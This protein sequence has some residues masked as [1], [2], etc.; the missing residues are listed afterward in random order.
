MHFF[1]QTRFPLRVTFGFLG[2]DVIDPERADV[3]IQSPPVTYLTHI[4]HHTSYN[5]DGV[6]TCGRC[7]LTHADIHVIPGELLRSDPC[8][9]IG[10]NLC[11]LFGT[12]SCDL[13]STPNHPMSRL[14]GGHLFLTHDTLGRLPNSF[15]EPHLEAFF[16]DE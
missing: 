15:W 5:V 1:I 13:L 9:F 10:Q 14:P 6:L 4:P 16:Y 8:V 7:T 12:H 3:I 11:Y 2:A